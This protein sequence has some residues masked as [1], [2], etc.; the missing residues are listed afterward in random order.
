MKIQVRNILTVALLFTGAGLT[1]WGLYIP[2]KA[3]L[4]QQLLVDAWEATGD[5]PVRPWP[6]ADTWPVARLEVPD[7][8]IIQIVLAGTAGNSLAFGP[9]YMTGSAK[10]GEPGN[11]VLA[12]HRDTHFRFLPR[13]RPGER[14]HL[15]DA[16]GRSWH[17]RMVSGEVVDSRRTRLLLKGLERPYLTLVSCY[18]FDAVN[19]GGPLRYLVHAELAE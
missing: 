2:A 11:A 14:I 8:G 15:Q 5:T 18:P 10:P 17:Y 16:A 19:A 12:G 7:H 13:L 6:W 9:G 4:A 3:W 1:T